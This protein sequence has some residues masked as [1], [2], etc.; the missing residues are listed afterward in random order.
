LY[1]EAPA[2]AELFLRNV[3]LITEPSVFV[4]P[5]TQPIP[6]SVPEDMKRLLQKFP[7]ILRWVM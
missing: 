7:S 6:D 5:A 4:S 1:G 3:L 2:A